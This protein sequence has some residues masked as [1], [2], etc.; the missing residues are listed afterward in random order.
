MKG[1]QNHIIFYCKSML[2][3]CLKSVLKNQQ[4]KR[5]KWC[6]FFT[7]LLG[8]L[9]CMAC[10]DQQFHSIFSTV[11]RGHW[12]SRDTPK[13]RCALG[14]NQKTQFQNASCNWKKRVEREDNDAEIQKTIRQ[15]ISIGR[16]GDIKT[17]LL[18]ANQSG[19]GFQRI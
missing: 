14:R 8:D 2:S 19:N 12:L 9:V 17:K 6:A 13:P 10:M 5:R 15:N 3:S 16:E 11:A 4:V 1:F 18:K 7:F